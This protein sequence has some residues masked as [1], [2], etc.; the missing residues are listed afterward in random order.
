MSATP[1][2]DS[3][4]ASPPGL[5]GEG[6]YWGLAWEALGWLERTVEPGWATLETGSG[7]STIIFAAAGAVHEAVTPD[8]EEEPRTRGATAAR[9][10]EAANVTFRIGLSHV[11]LPTL[12]P[13][14]L[15][16]VLIDGA[17]GF[18]YAILDWWYLASRVKVGG[19]VLI[20][21]AYLPGVAPIVDFVRA[22]PAWRLERAVSF[23]TAHAVKLRD[24]EAPFLAG[25]DAASGSR[26]RFGYLTPGR[27]VV[28]SSRQ[29]FFSTRLGLWA[30]GQV[31][32]TRS[33]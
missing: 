17:H 10:I 1:V 20:D 15:D 28:A 22:S 29:R 9:G 8:P 23:R 13:R 11:V 32:R 5:H 14:P 2:T 33:R 6:E 30:V 4:R 16:L 24:E 3:L 21:D 19:R 7:A 25:A 31:V 18:P 12:E 26:M 27:R